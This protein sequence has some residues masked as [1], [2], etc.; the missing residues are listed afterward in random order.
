[1]QI[2][3]VGHWVLVLLLTAAGV[4][5]AADSRLVYT[6]SI[7]VLG[8]SMYTVEVPPSKA[9]EVAFKVGT[10]DIEARPVGSATLELRADCKKVPAEVCR[11]KL[12]RVRLHTTEL[13]DRIRVELRG[14]SRRG[15]R[16]MDVIGTIVVPESAPLFVKMGIGDL[17]IDA[18]SK[19]LEVSMGI[20]D[21][22]V[23]APK[24]AVGSV[25]VATRIGDASLRGSPSAKERRRFLGARVD[26]RDGSGDARIDVRLKI[27]DATVRLIP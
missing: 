26:W 12:A 23:R 27:G 8:E 17:E 2:L 25:G 10:L 11:K 7:L 9:F 22:T 3:R 15:M 14:L 18:G 5:S 1:M 4:G 20:G 13:D 21:L 24:A 19:D 6:E 16:R